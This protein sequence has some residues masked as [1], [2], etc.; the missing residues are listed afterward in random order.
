MSRYVTYLSGLMRARMNKLCIQSGVIILCGLTLVACQQGDRERRVKQRVAEIKARPAE[1]VD[2]I[3]KVKPFTKI[4]YQAA[5]LRSPF[6]RPQTIKL[7]GPRP[8]LQRP[9]GELETF[10]LDALTMVG[11][12][13]Q[14][15]RRWALIRT[16]NGIVH[17]VTTGDYLG[18]HFG[19]ITGVM[20]NKINLVESVQVGGQWQRRKVS[21]GLNDKLS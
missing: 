20:A 12:I 17:S 19:R 5:H 10:P 8:D 11:T 14:D 15:H 2:V 1:V 6:H 21:L 16:P 4:T 3:P 7:P 9:K 13:T 18:R